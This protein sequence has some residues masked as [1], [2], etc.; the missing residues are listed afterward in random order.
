MLL[1]V[2][3]NTAGPN[4]N[5][6]PNL[7]KAQAQTLSDAAAKYLTSNDRTVS[8]HWVVGAEAAGA[9]IYKVVPEAGT[10]YHCGGNP[11][12]YPSSWVNPEDNRTYGGYALNQVAVGIELFGHE[13]DN[14][15]PNQLASLKALVLDI[16]SRYPI[17]KQ[18]GHIVAHKELEGDRQDGAN[19]VKQAIEWVTGVNTDV[20]PPIIDP[21]KYKVTI[22]QV[23][24]VRKGPGRDYDVV[25]TLKADP[26]KQ[27]QVDGELHGDN[28]NG[29][30]VWSHLNDPTAQ[31]FVSRTALTILH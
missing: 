29:D 5:N 12:N 19:W 6:S 4:D 2:C 21:I 13:N 11:P 14:L 1:L 18:K 15:G 22:P 31:G 24:T 23:A 28:I 27:Y 8:V 10:A 26:N 20:P 16:F 9:P 7:P 30:D 25:A 3:H 17:L